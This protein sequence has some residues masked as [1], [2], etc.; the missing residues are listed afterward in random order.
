[1]T[2][3]P[4]PERAEFHITSETAADWLIAKY[5]AI[6]A[7]VKLLT[8]QCQAAITRLQSDREGLER[9]YQSELE[10]F[11]IARIAADKRGRRSIIL[12]H[13]TCA[14]R[15]IPAG[16][17]VI[18]TVKALEYARTCAQRAVCVQE[19]LDT[20]VYREIAESALQGEGELLP[21]IT[22]TP[23]RDHFS[24]KFGR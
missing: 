11:V 5:H 6:D 14:L 13:G 9:L 22:R 4:T 23:E 20:N 3:E 10:T 2:T 7:E 18:D 8:E 17:K 16:L 1:M 12:P 19:T 21:G 15:K 24:I